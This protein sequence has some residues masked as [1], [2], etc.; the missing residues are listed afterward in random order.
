MAR[1]TLLKIRHPLPT[2]WTCDCLEPEPRTQHLRPALY[3]N[4]N[5]FFAPLTRGLMVEAKIPNATAAEI[6]NEIEAMSRAAEHGRGPS[7][8]RDPK[9]FPLGLQPCR[10]DGAPRARPQKIA[11]EAEEPT[12]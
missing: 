4:Q 5:V 1:L 2:A 10:S 3:V 7:G 6:N 12:G 11:A 9:A 8:S